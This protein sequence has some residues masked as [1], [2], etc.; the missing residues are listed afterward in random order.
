[1]PVQEGD[2]LPTT[3]HVG[4]ALEVEREEDEEVRRELPK[5]RCC[6]AHTLNFLATTD[7]SKVSVYL[8]E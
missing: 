4:E 6:G 2:S 8:I 1:M 7:V 3:I 5:H